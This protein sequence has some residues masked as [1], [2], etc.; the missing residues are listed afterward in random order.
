MT[1][2]KPW[3]GQSIPR[4]VERSQPRNGAKPTDRL[5]RGRLAAARASPSRPPRTGQTSRLR[6]SSDR[7]RRSVSSQDTLMGLQDLS[8]WPRRQVQLELRETAAMPRSNPRIQLSSDGPLALKP[9]LG[10]TQE[11]RPESERFVRPTLR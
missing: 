11:A 5:R 7:E 4:P 10:D 6:R 1:A 9:V 2:C 3:S 8:E